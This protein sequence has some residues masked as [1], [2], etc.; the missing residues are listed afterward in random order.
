MSKGLIYVDVE[1][2]TLRSNLDAV[3]RF[4]FFRMQVLKQC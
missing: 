4:F 1:V 2:Y 3:E